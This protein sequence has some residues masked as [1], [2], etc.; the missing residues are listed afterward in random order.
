MERN[1]PPEKR[2][3]VE[4]PSPAEEQE[5]AAEEID[6]RRAID[7]SA[8]KTTLE[9]LM[10]RGYSKVKVL[11][12]D[13]ISELIRQAVSKSIENRAAGLLEEKRAEI[14]KESTKLFRQL[15]AQY[16]ALPTDQQT[17][18]PEPPGPEAK[19]RK[20]SKIGDSSAAVADAAHLN[21]IEGRMEKLLGML[22]R[23]EQVVSRLH[24]ASSSAGSRPDGADPPELD[25]R[26]KEMLEQ[27]LSQNLDLQEPE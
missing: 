13:T 6:V 14:Q 1:Q 27:I 8:N 15:L 16:A 24:T 10:R 19:P 11:R 7:E 17:S 9:D 21:A 25:G 12:R 2:R 18:P 4:P 22:E 5:P 3:P 20:T 23:A 26:A